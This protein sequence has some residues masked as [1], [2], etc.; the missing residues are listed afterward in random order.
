MFNLVLV[1]VVILAVVLCC[2]VPLPVVAS[3]AASGLLSWLFVAYRNSLGAMSGA[4]SGLECGRSGLL[5]F[6]SL[7]PRMGLRPVEKGDSGLG[8]RG[9]E[10]S[11][12]FGARMSSPGG[13]SGAATSQRGVAESPRNSSRSGGFDEPFSPVSSPSLSILSRSSYRDN[14]SYRSD[15]RAGG[16]PMLP[17]GSYPW[18][19][20]PSASGAKK[21]INLEAVP[22]KIKVSKPTASFLPVSEV[23]EGEPR[24]M[25]SSKQ[26]IQALKAMSRKRLHT[27]ESDDSREESFG[28]VPKRRPMDFHHNLYASHLGSDSSFQGSSEILED[29]AVDQ[30]MANGSAPNLNASSNAGSGS[31]PNNGVVNNQPVSNKRPRAANDGGNQTAKKRNHFNNEILSSLSSS[32]ALLDPTIMQRRMVKKRESTANKEPPKRAKTLETHCVEV[33]TLPSPILK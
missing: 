30:R 22:V 21:R 11:G 19:M 18:L 9:A 3:V 25:E 28:A 1:P 24:K 2:T 14:L 27:S 10:S 15:D 32:L 17:P 6:A 26:I 29:V 23:S 7:S 4:T 13:P 5:E 33:Q 31:P 12:P 8:G 16:S 20:P